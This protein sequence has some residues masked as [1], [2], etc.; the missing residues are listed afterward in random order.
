[1][2][3]IRE[4][5]RCEG[6]TVAHTVKVNVIGLQVAPQKVSCDVHIVLL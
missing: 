3:Q 2:S 4:K 6:K 1:M 5:V